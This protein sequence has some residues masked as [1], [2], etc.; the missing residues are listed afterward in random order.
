MNSYIFTIEH[1]E[2][3]DNWVE[4]EYKVEIDSYEP[5]DPGVC[6]GPV[7]ACYPPEGGYVE[8]G[9]V[10]RRK[11]GSKDWEVTEWSVFL[12]MY[13]AYHNL[14]D[15]KNDTAM[16]KADDLIREELFQ[17]CEQE[18]QDAMYDAMIDRAEARREQE[19]DD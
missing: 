15:T 2:G 14:A 9:G 13:V 18:D 6:S 3:P 7:E 19:W 1:E 17:V 11:W 12:D 10:R 8:P 4:Y 5:Y 16:E